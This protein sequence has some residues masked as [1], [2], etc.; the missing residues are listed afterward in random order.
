MSPTSIS[1]YDFEQ[2]PH[3]EFLTASREDSSGP[4]YCIKWR[5]L[6]CIMFLAIGPNFATL[7]PRMGAAGHRTDSVNL[8]DLTMFLEWP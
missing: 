6:N 7:S 4:N 2:L 3:W 5:I 8:E 1:K